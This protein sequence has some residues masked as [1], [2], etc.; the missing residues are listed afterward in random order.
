MRLTV[1]RMIIM[2]MMLA[3]LACAQR[4][5]VAAWKESSAQTVLECETLTAK[6]QGGILYELSDPQTGETLIRN[7]VNQLSSE[8]CLFGTDSLSL[9]DANVEMEMGNGRICVVYRWPGGQSWQLVWSLADGRDLVLQTSA[10]ST[11]PVGRF[12]VVI[13]G[14]DLAQHRQTII[15]NF[16]VGF[17]ATAPFNGVMPETEQGNYN[18]RYVMPIVLLLEGDQGGGFIEGRNGNVDP[19][20][21]IVYGNGDTSDVAIVKGYPIPTTEVEMFE[22]RF[23]FYESSWQDA[24]DPYID[25]MEDVGYVPLDEMP[26]EWIR[27]IHAYTIIEPFSWEEGQGIGGLEA[28][29]ELVDPGET[30]IGKVSQ[31]R[32]HV[33]DHFW[34]DYQP[35]EYALEFFERAQELGFHTAVHY[36]C[37]GIDLRFPEL[38]ERFREGFC[39]TGRDEQGN[40]IYAGYNGTWS[41]AGG[42]IT[43][44][45]CSPAYKPYRDFLIEQMRPAIEAGVDVIYLDESHSALGS[46]VVDGITAIQGIMMLEREIQEAYPGVAVMTEQ[47]N[48]MASRWASFAL[49]SHD[50]GHSVSGY[51]FHRFI[52]ITGWWEQYQPLAGNMLEFRLRYG[53]LLPAA[54]ANGNPWTEVAQAFQQFNLEPAP[55]LPLQDNQLSAFTG[56]NGVEAFFVSRENGRVG[57]CVHMSDGEQEWFGVITENSELAVSTE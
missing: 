2:I 33:F 42:P 20:N 48:P 43:F 6:F 9:D 1:F 31:Y 34:G 46:F 44:V 12:N 49:T 50:L 32:P 17:T 55:R 35:T 27:N 30:L 36:N 56:D 16:G 39:E 38:I 37:F 3:N 29:A 53:Y 40:P 14:V 54:T 10:R 19:A 11:T 26:Q 25:W 15:S 23:R 24:V 57:L 5:E 45:W 7:D 52:K 47:F 13:H 18:E 8:V 21:I 22:I 4:V 51:I 28:L 41:N